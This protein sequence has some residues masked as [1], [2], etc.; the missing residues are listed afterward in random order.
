MFINR[1]INFEKGI[2]TDSVAFNNR[3]LLCGGNLWYNNYVRLTSD[4]MYKRNIKPYQKLPCF[5]FYDT[6]TDYP[7]GASYQLTG[8]NLQKEIEKGYAFWDYA[9]HGWI[10]AWGQL[11]DSTLYDY[12]HARSLHNNSYTVVTTICCH[13]N[14][15]DK[16]AADGYD[17][18]HKFSIVLL[19]NPNSGVIAYLGS[20]R[21]GFS[22]ISYLYSSSVYNKLFGEKHYNF[23]RLVQSSKTLYQSMAKTDERHRW[24][25]YSINPIGDPEMPL[26][27]STPKSFDSIIITL[28]GEDS[29][30]VNANVDSCVICVMSANDN[31]VTFYDADTLKQKSSPFVADT[32]SICITK[33]NYIPVVYKYVKGGNLYIQNETMQGNK[34]VRGDYIMVGSNVT[35]EKEEGPVVIENGATIL[36]SANGVTITRDFEVR[37]GAEFEIKISY[38]K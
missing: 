5:R 12:H 29:I 17:D 1:V 3:I 26:R 30:N 19:K 32:M 35:T 2:S 14:A 13:S 10:H 20:S 15:F 11:E 25:Q 22:D 38:Q 18:N 23:A 21:E 37:E 9:G 4:N 6:D 36:E 24:L 16:T 27:T 31:G 28:L 34:Y 33:D 8:D 7:E